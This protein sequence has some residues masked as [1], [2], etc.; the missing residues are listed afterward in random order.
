MAYADVARNTGYYD[1][2]A[3]MTR[4]GLITGNSRNQF[5]PQDPITRGEFADIM[6]RMN[7]L[8]GKTQNTFPDVTD[9]TP[10]AAAMRLMAEKGWLKGQA[11]GTFRPNTPLTRAGIVVALNNEP[12]EMELSLPEA[13]ARHLIP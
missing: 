12:N 3:Y 13:V 7:Q 9:E 8:I 4:K 10:N 6:A 1:D 5:R 11:D 2:L